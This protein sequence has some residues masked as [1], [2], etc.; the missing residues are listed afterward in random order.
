MPGL[1]WPFALCT[2]RH[3][4]GRRKEGPVPRLSQGSHTFG[5]GWVPKAT[6]YSIQHYLRS[7][8]TGTDLTSINRSLDEDA[9]AQLRRTQVS[10]KGEWEGQ[11]QTLNADIRKNFTHG[12]GGTIIITLK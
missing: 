9:L 8:K 11:E 6:G 3:S 7:Q 10:A 5:E 4:A 12:Q 1:G 2:S